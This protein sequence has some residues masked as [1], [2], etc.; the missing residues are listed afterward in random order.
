MKSSKQT[1]NLSGETDFTDIHVPPHM[2]NKCIMQI[3]NIALSIYDRL[4][5]HWA[6]GFGLDQGW[7]N[8]SEY[9]MLTTFPQN[10]SWLEFP[11]I[12]RQDHICYHWQSV[13]EFWNNALWDTHKHALLVLLTLTGHTTGKV[14]Q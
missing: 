5:Y 7:S 4:I 13:W 10:N 1:I 12:L 6:V 14:D 11:E 8:A 3:N 9:G 2:S